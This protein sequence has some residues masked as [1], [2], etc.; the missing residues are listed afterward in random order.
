MFHHTDRNDPQAHDTALDQLNELLDLLLQYRRSPNWT[1]DHKFVQHRDHCWRAVASKNLLALHPGR[2][3][4]LNLVIAHVRAPTGKHSP[5][6]SFCLEEPGNRLRLEDVDRRGLGLQVRIGLEPRRV[7]IVRTVQERQYPPQRSPG[8]QHLVAV[9][10]ELGSDPAAFA[11]VQGR[12]FG[13]LHHRDH[14]LGVGDQVG[15]LRL[16]QPGG[17]PVAFELTRVVPERRRRS[18]WFGF[19]F[20]FRDDTQFGHGESS[21]GGWK[22]HEGRSRRTGLLRVV[23]RAPSVWVFHRPTPVTGSTVIPAVITADGPCPP[24]STSHPGISGKDPRLTRWTE[25]RGARWF[26]S[27]SLKP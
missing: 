23:P 1:P 25:N 22:G 27:P 6:I 2:C 26:H 11:G 19:G 24:R 18:T 14:R 8:L 17:L 20:L 3:L 5:R 15:E 4:T 7:R 21:D 9:L 16:G 12:A 13:G 10:G